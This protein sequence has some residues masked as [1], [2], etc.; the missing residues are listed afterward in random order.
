MKN[1]GCMMTDTTVSV[2]GPMREDDV[3]VVVRKGQIIGVLSAEAQD[4]IQTLRMTFT[5][6]SPKSQFVP[7]QGTGVEYFREVHPDDAA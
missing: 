1:L 2:D 4:S 6:D 5:R 7:L 3:I